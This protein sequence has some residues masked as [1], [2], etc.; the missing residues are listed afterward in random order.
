MTAWTGPQPC[1][2]IHAAA[3]RSVAETVWA[4]S[5]LCNSQ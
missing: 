4:F 1:S 5:A 2:R 3:R